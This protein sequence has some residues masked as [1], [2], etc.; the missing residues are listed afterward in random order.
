MKMCDKGQRGL[1]VMSLVLVF[2]L[3]VVDLVS[4][5]CSSCVCVGMMLEGMSV[6]G[7]VD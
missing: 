6:S 1:G 5:R 7:D 3:W 2:M 4:S